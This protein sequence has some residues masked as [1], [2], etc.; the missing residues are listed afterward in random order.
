M[1]QQ[2]RRTVS[3]RREV[4]LAKR[5]ETAEMIVRRQTSSTCTL[6]GSTGNSDPSQDSSF[7][8]ATTRMRVITVH[9]VCA[10]LAFAF[11]FPIG[12]ILIRVAHFN[13]TLWIHVGMQIAAYILY[14]ASVGMGIWIAKHPNS[15]EIK[16]KHPIIGLFLFCLLFFQ[17]PAG[18]MHHQ[19]YKKYG[20]RT[21]WSYIHLWI[22]RVA[23]TLG[24]LNAGFG[25]M[26]SG[27]S[28]SGPIT[29]VVLA[30]LIWIAYVLSI[31]YGEHK[32]LRKVVKQVVVNNK[33]GNRISR[34]SF[35]GIMPRIVDEQNLPEPVTMRSSQ[36]RHEIQPGLPMPP[37]G[38]FEGGG[39]RSHPLQG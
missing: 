18:W 7:N 29:Y 26:L 31:V 34:L 27:T 21:I 37:M 39:L 35:M 6:T 32:R 4:P 24:I 1:G 36:E 10:C 15:G 9:A 17:A 3:V 38:Y 14:T 20:R 8:I 11:F 22:G 12:G 28:G 33:P 23:I 2:V 13:N 25:F 19:G 5:G 16:S 30:T